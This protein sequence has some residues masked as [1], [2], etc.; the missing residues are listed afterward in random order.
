MKIIK[1]V[2]SRSLLLWVFLVVFLV[3]S[4]GAGKAEFDFYSN[5]LISKES[6]RRISM[7]FQDASLKTVLK[8]FS[9]QSGLNFIA[10][11]NVQD[12]TVT[13]YL[14]DV[15][16]QEALN[17]IM[18]ANNLTYE[19]DPG[20][21]I[22]VVKEW[23]QPAVETITKI[24]FLKYA[25]L[26][27]SKLQQAIDDAS[28]AGAGGGGTTGASTSSS[29]GSTTGGEE[30]AGT[31]EDSIKAV[32]TSN[33]KV[34]S[35]S[36]TN[37]LVVTDIPSQ[38]SV[39][40]KVVEILDTPTPQ[41]MIEV[42][43]LDVDKTTIDELGMDL[44]GQILSFVGS[45]G[46]TKFPGFLAQGTNPGTSA[47]TYGT[48]SADVFTATFELLSTDTKTKFLARPRILTLSN[49]SAEIKITTNEAI[50]Q[51]TVISSSQS[52]SE[53]TLEAERVETGVALKVTPQVDAN[54]G[55]VTMF[56]QPTVSVAKTGATFAGTTYKDPETR[57]SIG[58]LRVRDGETIVVGGLIRQTEE[59][60]L[61]KMPFL[62]DIPFVGGLFRHK[63]KNVQDRELIVFITPHIVGYKEAVQL[64]KGDITYGSRAS[65]P[66]REQSSPVARK[67]VVD[68]MLERWEN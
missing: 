24:F 62:G 17:K 4:A 3:L 57:T 30:E 37:S 64:A 67:E 12:R 41:V 29:S 65:L 25:R 27:G 63:D 9:E 38:F 7:D 36:R 44:S 35:D 19:L 23:G 43:M 6:Y 56:V 58:T 49:E 16:L 10:S 20:S 66:F 28:T 47:F 8:V 34:V 68:S 50:G 14:V 21:N 18:S 39:I 2:L 11:Q 40:E 33:G 13:L 1:G 31:L 46:A 48:L 22:F 45:K 5:D 52:T 42:E 55:Y 61:K 51:N 60:T 54:T 26:K 59:T 32:L 15:P 53:T